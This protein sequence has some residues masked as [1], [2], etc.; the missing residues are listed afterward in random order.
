MKVLWI[1]NFM[2]PAIAKT[3]GLPATNKEGWLTG[4]ANVI[5]EHAEENDI[6]LAAAFPVP[7]EM[8][9][10]SGEAPVS[11]K[12]LKYYGFFEDMAHPETYDPLLEE[13]ISKIMKAF[14][15]DVVHCFGTE[16]GHTLAA[17]RVC[18][19]QKR[20]LIGIQGLCSVYADAYMAD[21][22]EAIVNHRTFR[23]IVKKDS[24]KQQRQ[25]FRDRGE[26]E[27]EAVKNAGNV[28]GRTHW[29]AYYTGLWNPKATYFPMNETLRASFYDSVWEKE[30][31]V[32]HRIFVTQGDYPIKGIHYLLAALP[33][34]RETFPDVSVHVAG[35]SPVKYST[36]KEKLKISAYGQYL[37]K[38]MK[39]GNVED[40]VTFLGSLA[41]DRMKQEYLE[42][43]LFLCPSSI[44]NSPNS[45]GEAMLLGVP[46]VSADVG[47][48]SSIFHGEK[49]G[50]L[51]EGFGKAKDMSAAV[52]NLVHAVTRMWKEEEA[53]ESFCKN[54]REHALATHDKENNYR[55]LTEIYRKIG[56]PVL[57]KGL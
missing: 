48:V 16:F 5:Q 54:A 8:D 1:C 52:D 36:W 12:P 7:A 20:L 25:K 31:S 42:C 49:D 11:G 14:S 44:E 9:G 4:L 37:R 46:C 38:L 35:N 23:D 13:R 28:T 22:P 27:I 26:R 51:Y 53:Q 24:L 57:D 43:A 47:G 6:E 19:D 18:P 40:A 21:L 30:K 3:L 41:A 34:L 10:T 55:T 2:L 39:Q 32:P 15:P 17:S 33:K 45:L 50:I 29:D 56:D